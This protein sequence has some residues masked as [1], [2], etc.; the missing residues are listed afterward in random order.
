MEGIIFAVLVLVVV[1]VVWAVTTY[2]KLIKYRNMIE[3]TWSGIDVALK[4]RFNLIP[5]LVSATKGY[6]Q[7][8]SD[9]LTKVAEARTAAANVASRAEEESRISRSLGG[10]LALAE[11]YPDLKASSNFLAL[12][13]SLDEIEEEIQQ[14]R[15]RY[16][17]AVRKFNTSVESF[18]SSII[19]RKFAFGR[20]NFFA[21]ELAT[22]REMPVVDLAR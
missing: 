10:L 14:A 9:V 18:P 4:R 21:L 17:Y 3:E 5:N 19:A 15:N 22:Q 11:S 20:R 12:H 7:H 8:E 1:P 2:N 6:S 13:H 16:N